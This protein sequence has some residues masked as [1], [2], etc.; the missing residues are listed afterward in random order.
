LAGA[1]FSIGPPFGTDT[2]I[3]IATAEQLP[4]PTVVNSEGVRTR[5]ASPGGVSLQDLLANVG[6]KTRT[7]NRR[8]VP[9]D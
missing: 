7:V 5:S 9:T 4:D 8:P 3:L 1:A 2:L 6:A